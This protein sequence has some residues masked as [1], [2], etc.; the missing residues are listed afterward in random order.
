MLSRRLWP[1]TPTNVESAANVELV[2]KLVRRRECGEEGATGRPARR[3]ALRVCLT[4]GPV[5]AA[6]S[7][8]LGRRSRTEDDRESAE[9]EEAGLLVGEAWE[10]VDRLCLRAVGG[11][12]EAATGDPP[13]P[14]VLRRLALVGLGLTAG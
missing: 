7:T 5:I 10:V 13:D 8:L 14:V 11:G 1:G 12:V 2:V 4:C 3:R 9:R 6:E